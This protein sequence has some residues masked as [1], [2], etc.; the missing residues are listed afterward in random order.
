[1]ANRFTNGVTSQPQTTLIAMKTYFF[2]SQ[3]Y[4]ERS[5]PM[6]INNKE[7]IIGLFITK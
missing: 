4:F 3:T 5:Q 6:K 2:P 1:M 7:K